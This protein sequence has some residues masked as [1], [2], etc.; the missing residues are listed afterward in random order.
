MALSRLKLATRREVDLRLERLI[1][2]YR[3][4]FD[5]VLFIGERLLDPVNLYFTQ[6]YLE[7]DKLALVLKAMLLEGYNAPIITVIDETGSR[8]IVDGHH[9]TLVAAWLGRKINS[10]VIIIPKYKPRTRKTIH[11]IDLVN[12]HDT[13]LEIICWRHMVNIVRFLERQHRSIARVWLE[14][15]PLELLRPTEMP[16]YSISGERT[17]S[18]GLECP[19]LVYKY[20]DE[21]FVLDGHH[22]VCYLRD[23]GE[24]EIP[25]ILVSLDSI[26]IGIVKTAR[27]LGY[28]SFT[29][30]Y[31]T[32]MYHPRYML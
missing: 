21:Y 28:R 10:Y 15:L 20:R 3:E 30:E 12:P 25:S 14:K 16:A 17:H 18:T 7:S 11:D 27:K 9:R 26:E 6:D 29:V 1:S 5:Y 31:C 24:K 2:F 13:P 19:I 23:L 8:Y 4:I 22:R 32:E